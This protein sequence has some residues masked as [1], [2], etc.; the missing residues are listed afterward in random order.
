MQFLFANT[1]VIFFR[2]ENGRDTVGLRLESES[3]E[4]LFNSNKWNS[5]RPVT[6]SQIPLF[7]LVKW[8]SSLDDPYDSF[9]LWS[10]LCVILSQRK[11]LYYS[12]K[13][14]VYP[15]DNRIVRGSSTLL[16]VGSLSGLN[17]SLSRMWSSQQHSDQEYPNITER[18]MIRNI[19]T[20]L[21][22]HTPIRAEY[23][24]VRSILTALNTLRSGI[25][26]RHWTHCHK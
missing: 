8:G 18:A 6:Y 14:S 21:S 10:S 13:S 24:M 2:E 19:P 7:L 5:L 22:T 12:A 20:A 17:I 4:V 25:F 11:N 1:A 16:V 23:T 3:L 9:W 15:C 26:Q